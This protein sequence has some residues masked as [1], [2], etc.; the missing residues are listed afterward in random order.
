M[1]EGR[2]EEFYG[3][4]A[5]AVSSYVADRLNIP[6]GGLTP[7]LVHE[8]LALK[9][10]APELLR[11]MDEFYRACDLAR[12]APAGTGGEEMEKCYGEATGILE[13]LRRAKW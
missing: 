13:S 5:R 4:I 1:K 7:E 3:G 12:F 9:G 8:R 6:A 10:A 2:A 11:R